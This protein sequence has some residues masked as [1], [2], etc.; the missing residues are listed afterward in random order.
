MLAIGMSS[1]ESLAEAKWGK[2]RKEFKLWQAPKVE[3]PLY[4]LSEDDLP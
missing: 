4:L 3:P 2:K 1:H